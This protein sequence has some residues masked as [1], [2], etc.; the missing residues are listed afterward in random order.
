M[1]PKRVAFLVARGT[2]FGDLFR[3][4]TAERIFD[5]IGLHS[6]T[7]R[8]EPPTQLI[9]SG[10][11]RSSIK[12]SRCKLIVTVILYLESILEP[13]FDSFVYF[14]EQVLLWLPLRHRTVIIKPGSTR[15][16]PKY[17]G[18]AI[19]LSLSSP[20]MIIDVTVHNGVHCTGPDRQQLCKWQNSCEYARGDHFLQ[21]ARVQVSG[22]PDWRRAQPVFPISW[23]Q[24]ERWRG[25]LPSA[26]GVLLVLAGILQAAR[27]CL[28]DMR[29][30]NLGTQRWFLDAATWFQVVV[31]STVRDA[32]VHPRARPE[33]PPRAQH[34][35]VMLED[36]IA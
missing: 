29:A 32:W 1:Q 31:G 12:P 3:T 21:A 10:H 17:L 28:V 20:D 36:P 34:I 2:I 23:K 14:F 6:I 9:R 7:L 4:S 33:P 15:H 11:I 30:A 5:P 35:G 13:L 8:A 18:R 24:E 27:A 19:D 22:A 16:D 25:A 26:H